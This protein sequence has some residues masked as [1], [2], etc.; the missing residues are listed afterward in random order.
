MKVIVKYISSESICGKNTQ[1]LKFKV[2][3]TFPKLK[4]QL[5]KHKDY[6]CRMRQCF[7]A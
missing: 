4:L 7:Y 1:S 6:V 2:S 3:G 5:R